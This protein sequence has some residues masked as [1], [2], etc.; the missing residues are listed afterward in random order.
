MHASVKIYE[1]L[2]KDIM[3]IAIDTAIKE[4]E[5]Y[6]VFILNSDN[7]V[8]KREITVGDDNGERLIVSSGISI[9]D[10]VV[11]KGQD[12]LDDKEIVRVVTE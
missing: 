5:I 1:K 10:T 8:S 12:Y 3:S 7:T 4:N 11:T 9:G 6:Y 2:Q